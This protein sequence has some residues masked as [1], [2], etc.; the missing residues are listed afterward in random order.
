MPIT[1]LERKG[2]FTSETVGAAAAYE[3]FKAF[4][5]NEAHSR[6][7]DGKV[8]HKESKRIIVGLAEG[9]VV[10]LV[11]EKRLPFT[12]ESEK[13]KFIK[14][15]QKHAAADAKRAVR[16]SGLYANHELD[17]LDSDEKLAARIM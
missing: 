5:N 16:E 7:I 9:R 11:E 2:H 3:A 15:A 13:V 1:P 8:T 12:S 14:S 10:K 4:E 17:P 6:G